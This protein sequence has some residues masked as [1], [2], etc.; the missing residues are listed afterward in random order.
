MGQCISTTLER[1]FWLF[2]LLRVIGNLL[3][4]EMSEDE[5]PQHILRKMCTVSI[6]HGTVIRKGQEAA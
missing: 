6:E 1:K 5:W 2:Q 4:I 3:G